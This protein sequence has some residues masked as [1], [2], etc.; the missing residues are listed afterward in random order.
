VFEAEL[1]TGMT[2]SM[3]STSGGVASWPLLIGVVLVLVLV[4]GVVRL[5]A[6]EPPEM[7]VSP[8]PVLHPPART[9]HAT[10]TGPVA[11]AG[12]RSGKPPASAAPSIRLRLVAAHASSH[13]V[14]RDR[15]GTVVWSGD[16]ALNQAHTLRVSAPVDV[17]AGD[18][19]AID[20]AVD[21]HARGRVGVLGRPGQRTL[22]GPAGG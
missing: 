8:V 7:L 4:W 6:A 11:A 22:H 15:T 9:D 1:A 20:V 18:A 14:V 19:G 5:F 3:R 16:L 10:V 13:V 17:R 21:G 2:G 12:S